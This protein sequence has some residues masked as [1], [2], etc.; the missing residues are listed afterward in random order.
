MIATISLTEIQSGYFENVLAT[1]TGSV[2]LQNLSL[3]P[4]SEWKKQ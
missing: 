4:L 1:A 3:I 2:V